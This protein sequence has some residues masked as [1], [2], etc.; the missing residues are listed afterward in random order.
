MGV[1]LNHIYLVRKGQGA[2]RI[3]MTTQEQTYLSKFADLEPLYKSIFATVRK[4]MRDEHLKADRGFF[5]RNF[6]GKELSTL[7][8]EDMIA[9]YSKFI[10][11]GSE[12]LAEF[13]ANRWLLRHIDIYNFFEAR[14]K[15]V[16]ADIEEITE[17]EEGFAN[18]LLED[19]VAR[20][21]AET[22]YIF[23]QFNCVALP[24]ASL[25]RLRNDALALATTP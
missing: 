22:S 9:V 11:A 3:G 19:S 24:K 8:V 23:V 13:I 17:L 10:K 1:F 6:P 12:Q 16:S 20:F 21:G 4:D 5:K 18:S 25:E 7:S 2:Y 14:L 15:T